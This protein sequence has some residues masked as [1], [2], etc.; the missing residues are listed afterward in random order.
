[1]AQPTNLYDRYDTNVNVREDLQDK[2]WNT[3]PDDVP[4]ST[5]FGRSSAANTY[6]EWLQD[7]LAPPNK[8]NAAVDGDD[9]TAQALTPVNRIGNYCQIFTKRP[10]VSRRANL[11]KKA[12]QG[13]SMAYQKAKLIREM[14]RDIEAMILSENAAVAGNSTTPSKSAA[15]GVEIWT[16]TDHGAGGSTPAHTSGAAVTPPT[17]GTPRD[18]TEA[19][20]KNV[21]AKSYTSSGEVPEMVVMSPNHKGIFSSFTG[22]AQSRYQVD[23][24]KQARII[25]GADIYVSNFGQLEIVPHYIM[26]GA[27]DVFLLN[28][29]YAEV[30]YFDGFRFK[31][32]G[33][34]GDSDKILIT[35]DLCLQVDNEKSMAK[36]ADLKP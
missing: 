9:F 12:G 6:H 24:G 35:A 5:A 11:V 33:P 17:P 1:M 20:L 25:A 7:S 31:E 13:T 28:T 23:N 22:I 30:A 19:L 4:V 3:D 16:N 26:A 29:D 8:D 27:T 10:A 2:I 34:T 36:I 21:V 32:M 18:F 14:K 15:L